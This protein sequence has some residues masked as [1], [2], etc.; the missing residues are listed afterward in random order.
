MYLLPPDLEPGNIDL[1]FPLHAQIASQSKLP[2][3]WAQVGPVPEQGRVC[4][5]WLLAVIEIMLE[6][7]YIPYNPVIEPSY[8]PYNPYSFHVLFH[9]PH[10]D[11]GLGW[12]GL[13]A[14]VF[15]RKGKKDPKMIIRLL[16]GSSHSAWLIK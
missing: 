3:A 14:N 5:R 2:E 15:L 9:Y 10:R 11:Q 13:A 4:Q 12:L 6:S 8:N 1:P 7:N 16:G